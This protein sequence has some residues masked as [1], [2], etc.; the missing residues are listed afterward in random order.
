VI[1]DSFAPDGP[2]HGGGGSCVCW[3]LSGSIDIG[4]FRFAEGGGGDGGGGGWGR[5]CSYRTQVYQYS[6][7]MCPPSVFIISGA[8]YGG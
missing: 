5:T 1:R 8:V 4:G 6:F 2:G 3:S 7:H